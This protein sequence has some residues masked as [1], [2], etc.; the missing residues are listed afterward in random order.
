ML[1]TASLSSI[2]KIFG[3]SHTAKVL[4]AFA[5]GMPRKSTGLNSNSLTSVTST[6]FPVCSSIIEAICLTP[7]DL[8]TPG[9]PHSMTEGNRFRGFPDLIS[10]MYASLSWSTA[11]PIVI[12]L[13]LFI[14]ANMM[15]PPK[16]QYIFRYHTEKLSPCTQYSR[17]ICL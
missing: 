3:L 15:I 16:D 5:V 10:A 12:A 11:L 1:T 6:L 4:S 9:A 13:L 2:W 17:I 7:C 8:P 14:P